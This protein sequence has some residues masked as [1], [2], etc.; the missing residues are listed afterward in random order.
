MTTK[1]TQGLEALT[2]FVF[3]T[4]M[5]GSEG[6]LVAD[7]VHGAGS[8]CSYE[9]AKANALLFAA[10]PEM[11]AFLMESAIL[12]AHEESCMRCDLAHIE[13]N[14][15]QRLEANILQLKAIA[16]AKVKGLL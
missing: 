6:S 8:D 1:F 13:C 3:Q 9:E 4:S 12:D 10:A 15:G 11:F 2:S 7:C 16:L 5:D 14:D